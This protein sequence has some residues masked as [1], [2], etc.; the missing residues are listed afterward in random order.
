MGG[1]LSVLCIIALLYFGAQTFYNTNFAPVI[2]TEI[3][4]TYSSRATF[5]LECQ[6]EKVRS[7]LRSEA[8]V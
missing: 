4:A 5:E 7:E 2:E 6:V 8:T 1:C 3:A